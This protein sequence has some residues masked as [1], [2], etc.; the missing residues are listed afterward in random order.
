M[1]RSTLVA[2]VTRHPAVVATV[3]VVA[4]AATAALVGDVG[5][6]AVADG[7]AVTLGTENGTLVEPQDGVSWGGP[8]DTGGD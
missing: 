4:V 2:A 1:L 7:S 3:A 8:T 6:L 5:Q